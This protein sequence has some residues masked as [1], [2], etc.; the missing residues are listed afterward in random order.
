M[1]ETL[2]ERWNRQPHFTCPQC[3]IKS[4]NL[5]DIRERYCGRCHVF[6][7]LEDRALRQRTRTDDD[8]LRFRRQ[9]E[10]RRRPEDV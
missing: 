7:A 6:F 2:I 5:N 3:G 4:W 10:A 8:R 9:E 1:T